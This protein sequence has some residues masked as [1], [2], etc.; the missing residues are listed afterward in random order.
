MKTNYKKTRKELIIKL[1]QYD[2]LKLEENDET[3]KDLLSKLN[4]IDEII[5]ENLFNYTIDRLSFIDRAIIRFAT[6]ELKY[7][8]TPEAII[9]NEAI[10]ITKEFTD[11]DDEKQHKFNNRLLENIKKSIRG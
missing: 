2:L 4:E 6:Y 7:T 8:K 11:L 1:Y 5:K 10:L 3:I 9:I